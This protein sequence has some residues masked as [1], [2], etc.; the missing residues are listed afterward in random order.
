[1]RFAVRACIGIA[2]Y[3]LS[4]SFLKH[5]K[6]SFKPFSSI[7]SVD[8]HGCCGSCGDESL[9]LLRAPLAGTRRM[10]QDGLDQK[11]G[12]SIS[13]S[14]PGLRKHGHY[15][16]YENVK[17]LSVAEASAG[18]HPVHGV[19]AEPG[20]NPDPTRLRRAAHRACPTPISQ[21]FLRLARARWRLGHAGP[22]CLY[23]AG[24]GGPADMSARMVAGGACD[25]HIRPMEDP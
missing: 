16:P 21:V 7:L 19:T 5:R 14:S 4:M 20:S 11:N 22:R 18:P 24:P 2:A 10:V 17:I 23:G 1:M 12:G 25:L 9:A 6:P 13:T 8:P 15:S 3:I